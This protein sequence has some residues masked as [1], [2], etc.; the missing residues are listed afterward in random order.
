[1]LVEEILT[2]DNYARMIRLAEDV[3]HVDD[4]PSQLAIDEEVIERLCRLHPASVQEHATEDGPVAWAVVIPTT[5]DIMEAFVSGVI[6]EN[7]L[8]DRTPG[9]G[10]FDAVYL[11]SALVLPEFRRQGLAQTL[12]FRAVEEIRSQHRIVALFSWGF[13]LE[14]DALADRIASRCGLPIMKR[15]RA[16]ATPA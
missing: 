5:R 2:E 11:C 9:S 13:S 12:L 10:P 7:E 15:D 6:G 3:F 16:G 4:D 8:L 14:G 1:M